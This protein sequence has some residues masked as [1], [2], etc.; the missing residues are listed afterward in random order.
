MKTTMNAISPMSIFVFIRPLPL[1]F[2]CQTIVG[3]TV[4]END[5]AKA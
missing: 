1:Q 4:L 2:E 3:R 5:F